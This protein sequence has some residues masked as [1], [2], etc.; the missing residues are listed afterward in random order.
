MLTE[1]ASLL[2]RERDYRRVFVAALVSN[3]GDWFVIVP[4]VTYLVRLTGHGVWSGLVL[5]VDTLTVA[6]LSPYAGGI[7][8]RRDRRRLIVA[9]ELV[10]AAGCALLWFVHTAGTAPVALIA[11]ATI[12]AAKAFAQPAETAALPNLVDPGDLPVASVLNGVAWGSMSAVGAALGGLL[13]SLTTPRWCF[14]V[15]LVSFV[16]SAALVAR[17]TRPFQSLLLDGELRPHTSVRENL[18]TTWR[19]SRSHPR[20]G[21]LLLVKNG[22]GFGNGI[23]A[24]FPLLAASAYGLRPSQIAVATGLFFAARGTGVLIGPLLLRRRGIDPQHRMSTLAI[25]M[26]TYGA[27]YAAVGWVRFL[28]IALLLVVIAHIGGG[29]NWTLST[30]AM[31]DAV[32][33]RLRGRMFSADLTILTICLGLSQTTAGL[34]S[35]VGDVR[36]VA[37]CFSAVTFAYGCVWYAV[38]RRVRDPA[39]EPGELLALDEEA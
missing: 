32:P 21:M 23:F 37:S 2:R 34:V 6:V 5:A 3:A 24:L 17:V 15:D 8:D 29:A 26:L 38:T 12:A 10:S 27:A 28:P 7:V 33:D 39:P 19:Y 36:V 35:E 30:Y 25:S 1:G 14:G 31:Q 13:A 16:V 4:L 22:V 20:T 18:T 9:C 11:V